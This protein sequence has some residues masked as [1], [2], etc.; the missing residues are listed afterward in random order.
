MTKEDRTERMKE[1]KKNKQEHAEIIL[2]LIL[3]T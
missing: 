2:M 3:G 1:K